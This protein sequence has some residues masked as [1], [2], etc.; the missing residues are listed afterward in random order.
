[1]LTSVCVCVC[2]AG[3]FCYLN[4]SWHWILGGKSENRIG[5][6]MVWVEVLIML[7]M[8]SEELLQR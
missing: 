6:S 4:V 2:F 7:V 1:M 8:L 3:F 5:L